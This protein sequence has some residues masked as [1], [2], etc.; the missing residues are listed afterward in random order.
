M[1][2]LYTRTEVNFGGAMHAQNGIVADVGGTQ[3][4]ILLQNL[5]VQYS[6]QVTRL[7]ELGRQGMR[8]NVYYVSGRAQG[9]LTA[10]HVIGPGSLLVPFYTSFSDVCNAATNNLTLNVAPNICGTT[11]QQQL[12]AAVEAMNQAQAAVSRL[13]SLSAQ[14]QQ[15]VRAAGEAHAQAQIALAANEFDLGLQLAAADALDALQ[16]ATANATQANANLAA[17]Q[18]AYQQA[19][20]DV[21]VGIAPESSP[22]VWTCKYCVLTNV[23]MSV[24]AQD[25]VI[26][27]SST[28]MFSGMTVN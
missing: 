23:G 14:A 13:Q 4:G 2:D 17:G 28:V 20:A 18:A 11:A 8:T 5:Q 7:Y 10:A 26:N 22:S 3:M 9:Q 6:Q 19:Q 21:G 1:S 16:I 25:F 15:A 24:A 27:E 12:D